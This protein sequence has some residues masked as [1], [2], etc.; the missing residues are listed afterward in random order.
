[1]AD[2]DPEASAPAAARGHLALALDL[3][4]LPEAIDLARRLVPYFSVAKVGLELYSAAGP[5]AV[6]ALLSQGYS[7]FVDLKLH[8]IPT[9]VGRA[10]RVLGGLGA[11]YVT[12]HI[13]GGAPMLAAGLD[14]L[15]QGAADAGLPT[16]T[17]VGVTVLTSDPEASTEVLTRRAALAA[18]CG[19]GG[20]VCAAPDLPVVTAAAPGLLTVVPGTRPPGASADDQARVTTPSEA[21]ALGAD[22]L[23]I[24]RP[25]THAPDPE[26]A[27]SALVAHLLSR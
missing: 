5:A 7:V 15:L 21:R 19:L 11:S 18:S 8:D 13:Q 23:V 4:S 25:V 12:L 1:M 17:A 24:G 9:T 22:L 14:G 16:P 26:A 10:A 6:G 3:P 20:V 27:A 2:R